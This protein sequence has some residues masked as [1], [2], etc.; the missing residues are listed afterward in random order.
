MDKIP[1]RMQDVLK[2]IGEN[3]V[4][5]YLF[6][7]TSKYPDWNVYQNLTDKGCDLVLI[8]NINNKKIKIEVKTRQ[9]LYSTSKDNKGTSH[10]T[11]TENEYKH[12]DFL[13]G[14][15][16]ELNQYYIVPKDALNE[17]KNKDGKVYKYV[18]YKNAKEDKYLN[19]W[20]IIEEEMKLCKVD[21]IGNL[22]RGREVR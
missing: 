19:N 1:Q 20:A 17:T 9:R 7:L 16:F 15:W 18:A 14:Y 3:A 4:L 6:V 11:L 21:Q 10:F 2:L 13:V 22:S 5:F 8:N 12:C